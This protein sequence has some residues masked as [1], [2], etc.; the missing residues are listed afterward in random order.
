MAERPKPVTSVIAVTPWIAAEQFAELIQGNH[1]GQG[2]SCVVCGE[3]AL[4]LC[5]G[6]DADA[7]GLGEE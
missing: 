4:F 3:Q 6:Q 1:I 2:E 5:G 7:E